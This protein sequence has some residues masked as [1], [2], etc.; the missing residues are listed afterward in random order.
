MDR[1]NKNYQKGGG[2]GE[3]KLCRPILKPQEVLKHRNALFL[4]YFTGSTVGYLLNNVLGL[5]SKVLITGYNLVVV[6][7]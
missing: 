3:R 5:H 1:I 4:H 7:N 6:H 2:V